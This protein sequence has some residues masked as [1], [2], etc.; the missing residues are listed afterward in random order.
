MEPK[1]GEE[2]N[3]GGC[4]EREIPASAATCGA[5]TQGHSPRVQGSKHPDMQGHT[6]MDTQGKTDKPG[7]DAHSQGYLHIWGFFFPRPSGIPDRPSCAAP[8][9]SLLSGPN[10][11]LTSKHSAR[12]GVWLL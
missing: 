11:A 12:L 9:L 10:L 6:D 1:V 2:K 4:R 5:Y 3:G 8:A 7:R